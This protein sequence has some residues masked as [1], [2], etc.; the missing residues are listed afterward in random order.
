MDMPKVKPSDTADASLRESFARLA[1]R[2]AVRNAQLT[3]TPHAA[4]DTAVDAEPA[5]AADQCCLV[6][7]PA[8]VHKFLLCDGCNPRLTCSICRGTGHVVELDPISLLET[9]RTQLCSCT[10]KEAKV[11]YLNSSGLPHRYL[12]ASFK[13][14]A[15]LS[16]ALAG[17]QAYVHVMKQIDGFAKNATMLLTHGSEPEDHFFLL[18]HGP[19]GCGK[20]YLASAL[21]KMLIMRTGASG[22]FIEF[23]QLLFLLRNCYAEGRSEEEILSPL[24]QAD[25]LVI[26]ELGKARTENEWQMER[27]DDL[28]NSRY[29][30]GKV[31]VFT[32][33]FAPLGSQPPNALSQ[34]LRNPPASEGFWTQSL[35]DRIGLRMY[36]RIMEVAE[37]VSFEGLPS[38]RR[39]AT[40]SIRA[41]AQQSQSKPKSNS[42]S[43]SLE[44][45]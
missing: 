20:T 4:V 35:A 43:R 36:D 25:I 33:N 22:K 39:L 32:T 26:D 30:A 10:L 40:E 41:A 45:S 34:G 11:S 29:N 8:G 3:T 9:Q 5:C 31:T 13:I 6:S 17:K 18:L 27:L 12:E 15:V 14:P 1:K 2:I 7:T 28:V 23:Q 42:E 24:R 44:R 21:L 16:K 37:V 19:V 38:L